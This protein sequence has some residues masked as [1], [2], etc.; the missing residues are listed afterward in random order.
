MELSASSASAI[1]QA[2]ARSR[3]DIRVAVKAQDAAKQQGEAA[4]QLIESAAAVGKTVARTD[5]RG[6]DV[7]A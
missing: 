7:T 3:I 4:I 6:L 1:A 2:D 5:S